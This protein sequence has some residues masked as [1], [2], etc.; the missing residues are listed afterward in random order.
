L[1]AVF[2]AVIFALAISIPSLPPVLAQTPADTPETVAKAY[3]DAT[4]AGDWAKAASLTHP[5]SLAQF[6]KLFEPI[7]ANEKS[8]VLAGILLG[9]KSRAEFDQL[10]DAQ[11]FVKLTG[12]LMSGIA[13]ELPGFNKT[14]S[15]MSFNI[16]GQIAETPDLVH[17]L[18]RTQ[19]PLDEMRLKDAPADLFKNI[20]VSKLEVM[21]LNRYENTWRMTLSSELEGMAQMFANVFAAIAA[22]PADE[23]KGAPSKAPSRRAKARKPARKP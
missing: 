20:T 17:L 14:L 9:V 5:E 12:S 11:L 7:F 1:K 19:V 6:K 8:A 15:K 13:G 2:R 22:A 3:V 23:A 4:L 21:T 16:I 18:Y 10:S